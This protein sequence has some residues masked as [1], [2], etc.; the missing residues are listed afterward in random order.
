MSQKGASEILDLL[1]EG[2][3]ITSENSIEIK[4]L[5]GGVSS[6]I[7]RVELESG[8]ICVKRA[9]SKLKVDADWHAPVERNDYEV[10]WMQHAGRI[11]PGA[12]PDVLHHDPSNGLFCMPF[13]DPETHPLW[14]EE[15]HL[16]R[17]NPADA[18]AVG[19][20]LGQI[21]ATTEGDEAVKAAFP[22]DEIFHAIRLEPYLLATAE[23]HPELCINLH[24]LARIT[25]ANSV[26]LVHGDVSP[27]NILIG[28]NSP[29]FLD[30]ECAWFGD[31]AFDVAF[32][33]NHLLLKCL[34]TPSARPAFR[35]CFEA[36]CVAY[37]N[38]TS[39]MNDTDIMIR[40]AHLLPGLFLAR[41]DGK[42][43]VEYVTRNDDK[44]LVREVASTF[45]KSPVDH[46]TDICDAWHKKLTDET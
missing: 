5:S 26:A 22:T 46:P 25:A 10:R 33:L 21:H 34:W 9:L 16:G 4:P 35:K 45:L 7:W 30:A 37:E 2:G 8:P 17:A 36:M 38:A 40:T 41:I 32:C 42:S 44:N 11:V 43:P 13:L 19:N 29:I 28:P 31:P 15:L 3:I 1:R 39:E 20:V 27:K 18:A 12:A 23:K 24:K 6:D 14:K